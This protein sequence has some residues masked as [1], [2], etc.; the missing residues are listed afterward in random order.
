MKI[1]K[2]SKKIS[3]SSKLLARYRNSYK[4]LPAI[5]IDCIKRVETNGFLTE[6]NVPTFGCPVSHHETSVPLELYS[7][8]STLPEYTSEQC[9]L[10]LSHEESNGNAL[11][12]LTPV[13]QPEKNDTNL[14]GLGKSLDQ[15]TKDKVDPFFLSMLEDLIQSTNSLKLNCIETSI[16]QE[17]RE[18]NTSQNGLHT[19]EPFSVID[20]NYI[21]TE[22][23][24]LD[25]VTSTVGGV[26]QFEENN[27]TTRPTFVTESDYTT[28][29]EPFDESDLTKEVDFTQDAGINQVSSPTP[30]I[31]TSEKVDSGED[32]IKKKLILS[33]EQIIPDDSDLNFYCRVCKINSKDKASFYKHLTRNHKMILR[34]F[35]DWR[36]WDIEEESHEEYP[37]SYCSKCDLTFTENN[38]YLD[39]FSDTMFHKLNAKETD[40][41]KSTYYQCDKC[42]QTRKGIA[43][44]FR[45][46]NKIHKVAFGIRK[47]SRRQ[48]STNSEE[49]STN[50]TCINK[51][52]LNE[53]KLLKGKV[54]GSIDTTKCSITKEES[55][56][57]P[58]D[59]TNTKHI[60]TTKYNSRRSIRI[61]NTKAQTKTEPKRHKPRTR[62]S[63]VTENIKQFTRATNS[64]SPGFAKINQR[65]I[66]QFCNKVL[67]NPAI[68]KKHIERKHKALSTSESVESVSTLP[69][70]NDTKR[71]T[72]AT[73]CTSSGLAKID[74]RRICQF[75]NK[76]LLNPAICKKHIER[77]H[78]ALS[79]SESVESVSTLPEKNDTNIKCIICGQTYTSNELL[80]THFKNNH[81]IEA[82]RKLRI[83]N[84]LHCE[85][86]DIE[87]RNSLGLKNH[88]KKIHRLIKDEKCYCTV[89]NMT[90]KNR[91]GYNRHSASNYHK[92]NSLALKN[93]TATSSDSS[94]ISFQEAS[95][96]VEGEDDVLL[97]ENSLNRDHCNACDIT[98]YNK[99]SSLMHFFK[100]HKFN[101][102]EV[103]EKEVP[104]KEVYK[105]RPNLNMLLKNEIL[106]KENDPNLYCNVC[107][108]KFCNEG[109][110][111][112]HLVSIHE[113]VLKKDK[114]KPVEGNASDKESIGSNS[115][116]RCNIC[117]KTFVSEKSSQGHMLRFHRV[118]KRKTGVSFSNDKTTKR[119][120]VTKV[121]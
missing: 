102:K 77:K 40:I 89:C 95:T 5:E 38:A 114:P 63:M 15:S 106:P 83:V 49:N 8:H 109:N 88:M 54:K 112:L 59:K 18:K 32:Y 90:F 28:I 60:L 62:Q 107:R 79:T 72:R 61:Y 104:E 64:T 84:K 115:S 76:V 46:C 121:A 57:K 91:H 30:E 118:E 41:F 4:N 17:T 82:A 44:L 87:F 75:C 119:P 55:Q 36:V 24:D 116:L 56:P 71:F 11:S 53:P 42:S 101:Y 70:Q 50:H 98:F 10:T 7:K 23:F 27:F 99:S 13:I 47:Y 25:T 93:S 80:D 108:K 51:K 73:N 111:K 110:F 68:C 3:A 113:M 14:Y 43:S 16:D 39:H 103:P 117:N 66:C 81:K 19:A 67:L 52:D 97:S 26:D 31:N 58:V 29:D 33:Y 22:I 74:Q 92:K 35:S 105:R 20:S 21:L 120:R 85:L 94:P 78:K 2:V 6:Q 86:C 45:H 9:Q 1:K 100:I 34:P 12:F 37:K 48:S 96:E 69:K 65:R